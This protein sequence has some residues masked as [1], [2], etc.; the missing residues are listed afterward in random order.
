M[1][2]TSRFSSKARINDPY[3]GWVSVVTPDRT[4]AVTPLELEATEALLTDTAIL[5]GHC[6]DM[7][8][9]AG[10]SHWSRRCFRGAVGHQLKL[11]PDI[12]HD[13]LFTSD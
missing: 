2:C 11:L 8:Q 12:H 1:L 6:C 4:P 3:E 7:L 13:S 5:R 10:G 9:R